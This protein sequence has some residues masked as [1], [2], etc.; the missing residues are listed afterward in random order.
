MDMPVGDV[1][2]NNCNDDYTDYSDD[3]SNGDDDN[4]DLNDENIGNDVMIM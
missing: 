3:F 4:S 2:N 1:D